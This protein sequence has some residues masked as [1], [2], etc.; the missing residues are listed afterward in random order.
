MDFEI[1]GNRG[2]PQGRKALVREREEYFRLM[3]QGVSSREACRIVGVNRM[4]GKRWRNGRRATGAKKGALPVRRPGGQDGPSRFLREADR[5]HIA[6]RLRE[7]ASIRTIAA[8]LGRS[9]STIS[10]EV[11]RNGAMWR[12]SGWAYRPHAAQSRADA[13]RPRPKPGKIGQNPELRDFIQDHLQRRWSPE[14]ICQAL[15]ARF[16]DRPEMHV[17]HETIYQALYVQGRGELRREL[18]QALRTGR[19]MRRPHRQSYKRQ[20]RMSA[21]MVMISERPAEVADRAIPGHWEGDLIIG[22]AHQSAIGT[23]VERSSRFVTLVHLPDGRLPSQVRDALVQTVSTLPAQLRRSLTWD[24]G[25]EMALHRQFSTATDM[26]VFF[27][28]PASPWQRGSNENTNG[29]L[30]QYFP[31]GTDL[32]R[33]SREDLDT[34]AAELNSRPRKT[35]GWETPAERLAKLLTTAS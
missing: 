30:R 31:K 29:L 3:D 11:R 17:V 13:R 19:V 28:D 24:Q 14:Q 32:A 25:S 34:V 33:H 22:K 6:D 26:P 10:R 16:P 9:P 8:E 21:G 12:S 20:P 27:C 7:K 1:R 18:T 35:L 2:R 5:I 15:R 23:L 4:T